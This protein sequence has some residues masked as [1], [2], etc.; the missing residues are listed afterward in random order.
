MKA[1]VVNGIEPVKAEEFNT[2]NAWGFGGGIGRVLTYPNGCRVREGCAYYRHLP[3][4]SFIRY[5]L[6]NGKEVSKKLFERAFK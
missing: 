2:N 6:A 4:H 5:F 3:S 1:V